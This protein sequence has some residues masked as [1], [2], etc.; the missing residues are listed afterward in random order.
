MT[1][2]EK[3][4]RK[5][6]KEA[7]DRQK[8]EGEA[9]KRR[10]R[11]TPTRDDTPREIYCRRCLAMLKGDSSCPRCEH[12]ETNVFAYCRKCL[13]VHASGEACRKWVP[14][15][16]QYCKQVHEERLS[17]CACR[18]CGKVH[19]TKDGSYRVGRCEED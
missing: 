8:L 18:E 5:L 6:L 1:D 15:E 16:C 4:Q 13:K 2:F 9:F 10:R 14:G 19:R 17:D 3:I 7:A 12:G 11:A